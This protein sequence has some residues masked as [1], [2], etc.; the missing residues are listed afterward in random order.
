VEVHADFT[1]ALHTKLSNPHYPPEI[2]AE[3]PASQP[4]PLSCVPCLFGGLQAETTLVNIT[5]LTLTLTQAETTLI[6]IT[7]LTLTLTQAETTLIN[8][9]VTPVGLEEQ[10]LV[11]PSIRVRIRVRVR[12]TAPGPSPLAG[13]GNERWCVDRGSCGQALVVK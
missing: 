3:P 10:L 2:Q 11:P 9:T 5:T 12:R 13:L 6:N 8:F 4:S 1:L 7:T